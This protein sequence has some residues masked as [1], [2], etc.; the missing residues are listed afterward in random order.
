MR[1]RRGSLWPCMGG[2]ETDYLQCYKCGVAEG[3]H[4]K[5]KYEQ[6]THNGT[7]E[8]AIVVSCHSVQAAP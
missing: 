2:V 3:K 5:P 7:H 1:G 8:D 6:G 4:R